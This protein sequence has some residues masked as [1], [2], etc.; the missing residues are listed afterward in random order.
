MTDPED[1]P[2]EPDREPDEL[3]DSGVGRDTPTDADRSGSEAESV[4][5]PADDSPDPSAAPLSDLAG[6]LSEG[7]LAATEEDLFE[8]KETPEI[9]R[10]A[11]WRQV[12]DEETAERAIEEMD[13]DADEDPGVETPSPT[14]REGIERVVEKSSYCHAC[15]HF[16]GPPEVRCT[17]GGTEILE[18]V[19]ME[20]FRVVDCPIVEENE[21]L[22]QF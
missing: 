16:S 10:E 5:D 22:E 20:H 2:D 4:E 12:A 17:H 18:A 11:L 9:D 8:R 19:D 13:I 1:D 15:P 14:E 7:D 6:D 21:E 3:L